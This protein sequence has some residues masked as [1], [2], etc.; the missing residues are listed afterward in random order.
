M[1][2]A[3]ALKISLAQLILSVGYNQNGMPISELEYIADINKINADIDSGTAE[4]FTTT[5]V[6]KNIAD[7]NSLA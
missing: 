5:Q 1:I 3:E 7:E 4:L 2:N 6:R